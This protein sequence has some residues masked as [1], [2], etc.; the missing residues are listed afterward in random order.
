MRLSVGRAS[1]LNQC[2]FV[3]DLS[4]LGARIFAIHGPVDLS[5]TGAIGDV[6]S[7]SVLEARSVRE[8]GYDLYRSRRPY[9]PTPTP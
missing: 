4:G 3:E 6:N 5:P 7:R 1:K 2:G 9:T 8:Y